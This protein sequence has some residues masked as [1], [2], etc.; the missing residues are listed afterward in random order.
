MLILF[1]GHLVVPDFGTLSLIRDNCEICPYIVPNFN[2]SSKKFG[3]LQNLTKHALLRIIL[4]ERKIN[5]NFS[6]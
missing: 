3:T 1:A 5:C 2:N 6:D 4:L